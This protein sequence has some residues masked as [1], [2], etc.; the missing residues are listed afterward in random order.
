[1][2]NASPSPSLVLSFALGLLLGLGA[3][4]GVLLEMPTAHASDL[5][6]WLDAKPDSEPQ[7][8]PSPDGTSGEG[9]HRQG[10][11]V[12]P[13]DAHAPS[14]FPDFASLAEAV[15]PAVVNIRTSQT[16]ERSSTRPSMPPGMEE[17]LERGPFG[18]RSFPGFERPGRRAFK[19]PSL[20]S[21]FVISSDGYIV[22]N[23]HVVEDVDE[24]VVVFASG[25]E[26]EAQVVG[27]DPKT[28]IA[29]IRVDPTRELPSLRLGDSD[30]VRPGEWVV[31]I[32]NPFGLEHTVTAGIVSAKHRNIGQGSYDD[33]IQTDAAINPGNSG[34][35]LLNL[36]GE[37]IGINTAI[38]P[39]AN[40]IGFTVPINMA[41]AIL[42]QL[43]LDG[44]VTRGWLGVVIQNVTPELAE[45]F[46]LSEEAGAL[47]SRV[48][49]G[50]PAAEAEIAVGDVIVEFDGEP[51]E[52]WN[53]LPRV[54]AATAVAKS[55]WLVVVRDGQRRRVELEVGK[56]EEPEAVVA[57]AEA[58]A[59][60]F[61]LTTQPWTQELR[62]RFGVDDDHGVAVIEVEPGSPADEAGVRP[63]DVIL[64]VNRES[65]ASPAE[66][67]RRLDAADENVLVLIG[68]GDSNLFVPMK[69]AG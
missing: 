24:I 37:V 3:E 40:T 58:K 31:A 34:G 9:D 23:N 56:M 69:R 20:G 65:V 15:S 53:E 19:V 43:R 11:S 68:R 5:F 64:E 25:E 32:G 39:R 50:S 2:K 8:E 38:N 67:S 7:N 54:V 52:E 4:G 44:R 46:D 6:D 28:D 14:T 35:P 36:R 51:I 12:A 17:F 33:F 59:S 47:V 41:K 66:L 42:P 49:P 21:G 63:G 27:R 10:S 48:M 45:A 26:L 22:T 57:R 61:G 18:G 29:L 1:M 16:I 13:R 62:E 30:A 55:V 60:A